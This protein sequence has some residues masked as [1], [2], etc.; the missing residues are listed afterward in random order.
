[1]DKGDH[2]VT[3]NGENW[4]VRVSRLRGKAAG[5]CEY[6]NK[7]ILVDSRLTGVALLETFI[8]E[9]LHA[10]FAALSEEA[11]TNAAAEMAVI[12]DRLGYNRG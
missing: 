3:I 4:L 10:E 5:W 7:K 9:I 6:N 1:M 12:L 8:H 11:V 2:E